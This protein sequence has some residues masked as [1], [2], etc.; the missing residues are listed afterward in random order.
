L[1]ADISLT[2]KTKREAEAVAKAVSPDNINVPP[3]MFIKTTRRGRRVLTQIECETKLKTFMATID[4][5]LSAV[6]VA[7]R[8]LSAVKNP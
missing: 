3:N 8:V 1:Q 5:L 2:Y 7:E 6:S 4:D